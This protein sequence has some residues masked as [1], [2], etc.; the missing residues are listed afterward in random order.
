VVGTS[1]R[2][3]ADG[4]KRQVERTV[5]GRVDVEINNEEEEEEEEG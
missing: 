4:V 1:R 5:R 2:L 3:H